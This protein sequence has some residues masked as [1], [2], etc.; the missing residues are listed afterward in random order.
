MWGKSSP[1]TCQKDSALRGCGFV[2][3]LISARYG[4][5]QSWEGS[6]L[7]NDCKESWFISLIQWE[8][9]T[10]AQKV[11]HLL[12]EQ[13]F[14]MATQLTRPNPGEDWEPD[15]G[16]DFSCWGSLQLWWVGWNLKSCCWPYKNTVEVMCRLHG[17]W[18]MVV[19]LY[20]VEFCCLKTSIPAE[21]VTSTSLTASDI[22]TSE[23]SLRT[24]CLI[25]DILNFWSEQETYVPVVC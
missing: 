15:C 2:L 14:A 13:T 8:G 5:A 18:P 7:L 19:S 22:S 16:P 25:L 3:Q 4:C 21:S 9:T 17:C 12:T 20:T 23:S 6:G 11:F 24:L 10:H 1:H